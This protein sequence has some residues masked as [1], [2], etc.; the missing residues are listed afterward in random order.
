[1]RIIVNGQQ[2]F[3]KSVLEALV[4]RGEDVVAV[5]CAPDQEGRRPDPLKECALERGIPVFQPR[6]F[7]RPEVREQMASLASDLCVMAYVTLFVPEAVLNLPTLGSIQYHPSL[8]PRHRGPSSIN[9]PIIWGESQTGLSIFWPDEGLDEGPVLMQRR[10]EIDDSHTLGTLYF[11]HLFPMGVDALME[12]VDQVRSGTAPKHEQDH[13]A[14]TYEGWCRHELVQVNWH[15]PLQTTWNLVRGAD[16]APGAWTTFEGAVLKL[17]DAEKIAEAKSIQPGE[18]SAVDSESL[19]L[20]APDGQLRIKR[21][22]PA[23]GRKMSA[24]QWAAEVGLKPGARFGTG[25][26]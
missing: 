23:G 16:P 20:A 7:R 24:G 12:S 8:L 26:M 14:A 2:A 11:N 3:G 9:W 1:M 21:V 10:V 25:R 5:Y 15:L 19:T 6:S 22:R 18:V 4:D 13:S 17:H